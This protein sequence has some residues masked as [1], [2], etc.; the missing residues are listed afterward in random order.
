MLM[1]ILLLSIIFT[2]NKFGW[3]NRIEHEFGKHTL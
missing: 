1:K 3:A 2:F